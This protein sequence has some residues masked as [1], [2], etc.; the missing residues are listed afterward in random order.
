ME[1]RRAS[2][3]INRSIPASDFCLH[4]GWPGTGQRRRSRFP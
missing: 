1:D 3:E 2:S 4:G